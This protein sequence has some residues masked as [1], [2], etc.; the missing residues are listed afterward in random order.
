VP[1]DSS[2]I[3]NTVM[4]ARDKGIIVIALDT[5]LEP[6]EAADATFATDNFRAGELTG[7]W[8]RA[9]LG[10]AAAS[11]RI[12][13]LDL[14]PSQPTVDVLRNRAS[15]RVSASISAT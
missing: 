6:T 7:L 11:A 3:V 14:L 10:A 4:T 5:P 9:Q 12:A 1:T 8:A 13:Y 15:C 2:A